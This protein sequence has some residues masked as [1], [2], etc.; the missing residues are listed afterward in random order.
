MKRP[1]AK[2]YRSALLSPAVLAFAM[3]LL[4][5]SGAAASCGVESCP[6]DH[7]ALKSVKS[8]L[9]GALSLSVNFEDIHQDVPRFGRQRVAFQQVRRP[10]HDEIETSTR[11]TTLRAS[12]TLTSTWSFD[13]AVPIVRRRHSHISFHG[14][15]GNDAEGAHAHERPAAS[16]EDDDDGA[17]GH[18]H[19]DVGT[20]ETWH[21]TELGDITAWSRLKFDGG[22]SAQRQL[23]A[24]LGLSLPTASTHVRNNAG[25]LA[26][27]SLQPGFGGLGILAELSSLGSLT[28]PLISSQHPSRWYTS[29]RVRMNLAGNDGYRFGHEAL[30]HVGLKIPVSGRFNALSQVSY[31]WR[32]KDGPGSTGELVDA[33][34][35]TYAYLSPGLQIALT[36]GLSMYGY[37]QL[38]LYQRVN[39]VQITSD[40]NL[41]IGLGFD[42]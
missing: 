40:R 25:T 32:G 28:L 23:V 10:D 22:T 14:H 30:G 13:V 2:K 38:P 35:G 7:S 42:R 29:A 20:L 31:S 24:G 4:S 39:D 19:D 34:G 18:A 21:Y 1:T 41:M 11:T 16:A 33:T 9:P 36:D 17:A 26:E 5:S 3:G 6:L 37:Y 27:P 15:H 12:Y 8:D